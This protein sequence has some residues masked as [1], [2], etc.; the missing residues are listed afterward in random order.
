MIIR[1]KT[2]GYTGRIVIA[3]QE[4]NFKNGV[5]EAEVDAAQA[6]R[7]RVHGHTVEPIKKKRTP[8]PPTTQQA[9]DISDPTV[10]ITEEAP[11]EIG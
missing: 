6:A 8:R 11:P 4:L 3:C 2:P 7:I 9:P 5:A 10:E 1:H